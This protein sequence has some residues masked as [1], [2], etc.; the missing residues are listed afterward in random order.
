MYGP[1]LVTAF[2]GLM[3]EGSGGEVCHRLPGLQARRA[4]LAL[5]PRCI[6]PT[7]SLLCQVRTVWQEQQPGLVIENIPSL[8]CARLVDDM[9]SCNG[10][11][12][13]VLM[14]E[15]DDMLKL[16]S[17]ARCRDK[18]RKKAEAIPTTELFGPIRDFMVVEQALLEHYRTQRFS[19]LYRMDVNKSESQVSPTSLFLEWP[20]TMGGPDFQSLQKDSFLYLV[21]PKPFFRVPHCIPNL[22]PMYPT[23]SQPFCVLPLPTKMAHAMKQT[24]LKSTQTHTRTHA[25]THTRTRA[26]AHA[27]ARR[28]AGGV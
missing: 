2:T 19:A 10:L 21:H 18:A 8:H 17:R 27:Q 7:A 9:C 3:Q 13:C 15:I 12:R 1:V 28:S 16:A 5:L 11:P 14:L 6:L 22:C 23:V 26:R 4:S 20:T 24:S 25:C